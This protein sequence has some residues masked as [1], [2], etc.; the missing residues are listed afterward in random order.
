MGIINPQDQSQM[1]GQIQSRK[2]GGSLW[3]AA[4]LKL[5][6]KSKKSKKRK[7]GK[8]EW[9][10][11]VRQHKRGESSPSQVFCFNATAVSYHRPSHRPESKKRRTC[12][13]HD[14]EDTS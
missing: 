14:A 2:N 3:R 9:G 11:N 12:R 5:A 1:D 8:E 13:P 4:E 10:E 6:V 7:K